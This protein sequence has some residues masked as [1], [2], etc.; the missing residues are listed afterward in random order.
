MAVNNLQITDIYLILNALHSQATGRNAVAP[1][2]TSDFV[3]MATATLA[4]GT[5]PVYNAM[6]QMWE[7]TIYSVRPYN[8]K[9]DI[10]RTSEEY[11]AIKRKIN[12]GDKDLQGASP[13]WNPVDG[14]SVDPWIINKTPVLET[15]FY[16]SAVYQD[17]V[18]HFKDQIKVAMSSP[19][20]LGSFMSGEVTHLSNKYEQWI[21]EQNRAT[22]A[23]FIG[24]KYA[25]N[26]QNSI[27]HLITEYNSLTGQSLTAQT[28]YAPG[29]IE[30]FFRWVRARINTLSR[31]M[32]ERSA[33]FQ[34]QIGSIN[35]NRHTPAEFQKIY[36]RSDA[37]DIIDAMVNTVTYHDEPLAYA[38]VQ[39][40]SYWQGINQPDEI[41]VTPSSIDS[42]GAV[43]TETAQNV[44]NLFG[45]MFDRDAIASNVYMYEINTS[46]LNPRGRYYNSV[47]N[48]RLQYLNDLTEKAIILLLD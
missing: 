30:P 47:L 19:E 22:V 25:K 9:F 46:P 15:H 40:V 2:N 12:Y 41:N 35:I 20:E 18:T 26:D 1:V 24:A 32:S 16:G 44:K 43:V 10:T 5:D 17:T 48:A 42:T 45:L 23:N 27:I 37:L 4:A 6:A 21:E 3:S 29:N 38:D 7:R 33:M 39:G 13:A 8:R 36:L 11:G 34:E 31:M 28:A 14:T